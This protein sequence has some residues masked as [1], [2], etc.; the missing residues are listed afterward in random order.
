METWDETYDLLWDLSPPII[1]YATKTQ[2]TGDVMTL[3]S[4]WDP[5]IIR[6]RGCKGKVSRVRHSKKTNSHF[7]LS[8]SYRLLHRESLTYSVNWI[9]RG[10]F[11]LHYC[12]PSSLVSEVS[13]CLDKTLGQVVIDLV[14]TYAGNYRRSAST[15]EKFY[16]WF[17]N[18]TCIIIIHENPNNP[19]NK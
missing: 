8:P 14:T 13:V 18:F 17:E 10:S 5:V 16:F 6:R 2:P 12:T 3:D 11:T 4:Y 19:F 1:S 9:V 7:T 15:E